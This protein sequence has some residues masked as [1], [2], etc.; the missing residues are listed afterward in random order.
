MDT[1]SQLLV[2]KMVLRALE[3]MN[4]RRPETGSYFAPPMS[5]AKGLTQR[6]DEVDA[7]NAKM[8]LDM[9]TLTDV[10][11]Y[12]PETGMMKP[13]TKFE[14]GTGTE[15]A[16]D[17]K[18]IASIYE[19]AGFTGRGTTDEEREELGLTSDY[20][21]SPGDIFQ[22]ATENDKR[23]AS[24]L[25]DGTASTT[26]AFDRDAFERYEDFT[27]VKPD[28]VHSFLNDI[29]GVGSATN[30]IFGEPDDNN[31][32]SERE[33][34]AFS[35]HSPENLWNEG[36]MGAGGRLLAGVTDPSGTWLENPVGRLFS[37]LSDVPN[38][39]VRHS[40]SGRDE[41]KY[42][43]STVGN[44]INDAIDPESG[45]YQ[46]SATDVDM[47]HLSKK[48]SPHIPAEQSGSWQAR[49]RH[50]ADIQDH[51]ENARASEYHDE[52]KDKYGEHP[53]YLKEQAVN[54][55]TELADYG[56]PLSFV[57]GGLTKGGL[58]TKLASGAGNMIKEFFYEDIPIGGAIQTGGAIASGNMPTTAEG[59]TSSDRT[60]LPTETDTTF[61]KRLEEEEKARDAAGVFSQKY[62]KPLGLR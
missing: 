2:N 25:L 56:A 20:D 18:L 9:L 6:G 43:P 14:T 13:G 40:L 61:N 3:R 30:Y 41:S 4:I 7:E 50:L 38:A 1:D 44:F 22:N 33:D 52:Y 5:I 24:R 55:G 48:P 46:D 31:Y 10:D 59:W 29:P 19:G 45:V 37:A 34:K 12:D 11:N 51:A 57:L 36:W 47:Y 8:F 28:A 49:Q 17:P 32:D 58:L 23:F 16:G 27:T 60:D 35:S 21:A 26:H 39:H 53:S 42:G 54:L 15:W 62:A